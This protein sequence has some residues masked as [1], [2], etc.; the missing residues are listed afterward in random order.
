MLQIADNLTFNDT[1]ANE[2]VNVWK[3]LHYLNLYRIILAGIFVTSIFIEENLPLLGNLDPVGFAVTSYLYM[4]IGALASFAIHWRW[5]RFETTVM[6][7]TMV[8][9]TALTI[10]MHTSGGI[11]TGLGMLIVVAIAG[12]SLL[13]NGKAATLFAALAALAI[14]TDQVV[15]SISQSTITNYTQAGFLG[16]AV[17]AT[18]LLSHVLSSRLRETEQLAEQRGI[19]L[20]NMAQL[21]EYVIKRLY[22]GVIV[23]D[24]DDRVRLMNQSA[25]Q[26]LGLPVVESSHHLSLTSISEDLQQQLYE[27]RQNHHS[28]SK[29]FRAS[30]SNVEVMPNFTVLGSDDSSATLIF[31]EDTARMAQQAQQMKLASLGRLTASIAHE[32]RNPIGAISHADQLLAE[33]NN[34]DDADKRLTEI[35]HS[36]TERVNNIIENVLQLSRRGNTVPESIQL[37]DWLAKFVS[38]FVLSQRV[39]AEVIAVNVEPLDTSVDF[40]KTQLHQIIW[41]LSHN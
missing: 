27:W 30:S 10:I 19:D 8:D 4:T 38:E 14:L 7:L 15:S 33:S 31:L 11:E 5:P 35:I 37:K 13:T 9:I 32:I 26:L 24:N 28:E 21:N 3:S 25:W 23:V 29:I 16:A 41:N 39:E 12:N 6:L 34:L 40:D 2:D 22:S 1:T 20:A 36:H 18:A 17:F